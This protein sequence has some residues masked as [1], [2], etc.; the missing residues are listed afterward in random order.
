GTALLR[1]TAQAY[2][3]A[4][5]FMLKKG[6]KLDL[7]ALRKQC[8]EAGYHHV[9]QVMSPGEFSVRGGL[10]DLFPMGSALP[11]R[12]DLFDDEIET[13]RTFDVDTQRSLYPVNEI[14]L[15]P[16]RE[17]PLDDNGIAR[18]RQQFRE[19]FEGDPS[20]S[21]IYKDVSKGVASGGIEW[22][23]PLFFEKTATLLDYLPDNAL[24]CLHGNLDL[25]AQ[26]FWAEAQSRY[27][28]LAH[29]IER[30]I[31]KPELLLIKAD[32]FF[33]QT[34]Q[35]ARLQMGTEGIANGLTDLDIERRAEHPLH[36]LQAFINATNKR[37][38]V[39]AE[40]L[41]RRETILQLLNSQDLHLPT[42]ET[43]Q[44]FAA[45][46]ER[47]MLGI[48]PLHGGFITDDFVIITEAE[49]YAAQVRQQRRR[50]K[51]RARSTEGMLK[52]L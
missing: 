35:Y 7:E 40:S 50:D 41:G 48:S 20:R 12:L 9:S 15:L 19:T 39:A 22:Y 29:D 1:L 36:K 21:R 42:C 13:I 38:L 10:V 18:F 2:L 46:S 51:D 44:D 37:V 30:P 33:S 31:L 4:H 5:T 6:Q 43:W 16:A 45:S 32:D 23:L 11:Y 28:L 8:A 25:A 24:L 27:R 3:A 17:F 34:H 47:L 49:L 14:R 52:D 26:N